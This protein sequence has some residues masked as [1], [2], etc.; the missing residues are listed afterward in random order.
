MPCCTQGDDSW[1]RSCIEGL[2]QSLHLPHDI[3]KLN[4][5]VM[6]IKTHAQ[7]LDHSSSL[8]PLLNESICYGTTL[9]HLLHIRVHCLVPYTS[10]KNDFKLSSKL[11]H[12]G[13]MGT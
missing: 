12:R 3:F 6:G 7:F 8:L 4:R 11:V 13:F 1:Y 2:R 10:Q 5:I 9:K